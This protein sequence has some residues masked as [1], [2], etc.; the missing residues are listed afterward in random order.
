MKEEMK[1]TYVAPSMEVCEMD[2]SAILCCSDG[3]SEGCEQGEGG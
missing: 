2:C 3:N 1:K